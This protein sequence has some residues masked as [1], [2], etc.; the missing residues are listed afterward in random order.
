MSKKSFKEKSW[1]PIAVALCIAVILYVFLTRFDSVWGAI[2]K[3]INY[4]AP[5][6]TGVIIAYLINPIALFYENQVFKRVKK[7]KLKNVLSVLCAF[8]SVVLILAFLLY[9]LIPQLVD[10]VVTFADNLEGYMASL[11]EMLHRWGIDTEKLKID[12]F[13]STSE[14]LFSTLFKLIGDN[15]REIIATSASAGKQVVEIVIAFLLSIYILSFKNS[16]KTGTIKL[17]RVLMKDETA[18]GFLHFLSRCHSIVNRYVVYSLLDALIIGMANAIFMLIL[19]LPYIGLVSVDVAVFNLIPTFGPIIGAV[20]GA[21][22]LLMVKP[23]YALAFLIFTIV[24]QTIDGYYI[25]PKMFGDTLGVSG[26]W[27]LVGIIVGGR[28]FGVIGILLAIPAVAIL[29]FSYREYFF[30][31]LEK[32]KKKRE[33]HEGEETAGGPEESKAAEAASEPYTEAP[34]A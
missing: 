22:V 33:Q 20:I 17:M 3:F 26:L 30:P 34:N 9:T 21:F 16:L 31:W 7:E 8:I 4:F 19:R 10:S 32:K 24:L 1:Y 6:I 11:N 28:M 14:N 18:E 25:K 13:I 27:I 12:E 15:I 5:L 2:R 23:W 29:D